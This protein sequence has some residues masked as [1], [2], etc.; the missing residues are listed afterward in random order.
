[1][2]SNVKFLLI[3]S[4]ILIIISIIIF[5]Y[6]SSKTEPFINVVNG[7]LVSTNPVKSYFYDFR[8]SQVNS[9]LNFNNYVLSPNNLLMISS[10]YSNNPIGINILTNN[11]SLLGIYNPNNNKLF[12]I[13]GIF[14]VFDKNTNIT[15]PLSMMI[16]KPPDPPVAYSGKKISLN[17]LTYLTLTLGNIITNYKRLTL[18]SNNLEQVPIIIYMKLNDN[19]YR[20][21]AFALAECILEINFLV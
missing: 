7:Y 14:H 16:Q 9:A 4:I 18:Y 6:Y 5:V 10:A 21:I 1:M 2:D 3:S 20:Y 17:P 15:T 12:S 11:I 13:N 19:S 8:L